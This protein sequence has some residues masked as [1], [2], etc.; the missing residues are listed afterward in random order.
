MMA[1]GAGI[2]DVQE[3]LGIHPLPLLNVIPI[4]QQKNCENALRMS[5]MATL[6][7]R[8]NFGLIQR[9]SE[10]NL[11]ARSK[12]C[13][14]NVLSHATELE[15]KRGEGAYLIDYQGQSYLDFGAGIAVNATGHCHPMLLRPFKNRPIIYYMA[16]LG[17]YI[18]IKTLHWLKTWLRPVVWMPYFLHKVAQKRSKLR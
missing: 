10:P 15:I 17:L 9:M 6:L 12:T 11:V 14:S 16:V 13:L 5:W 4:F 7:N 18:M 3:F 1:N 2:R 8:Y